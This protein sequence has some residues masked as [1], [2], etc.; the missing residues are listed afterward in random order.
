MVISPFVFALVFTGT[1]AAG[2]WADLQ[3]PLSRHTVPYRHELPDVSR[4]W[5]LSSDPEV[6][7][8]DVAFYGWWGVPAALRK[9]DGVFV[10][11]SR[12]LYA[13]RAEAFEPTLA[14]YGR[15]YNMA[16][17]GSAD[18]FPVAVIRK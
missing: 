4:D 14:S 6:L 16:F 7:E 10:G 9:A 17:P 1:V 18:A 11:N 13:F 8:F 2:Y 3:M 5:Y 15:G 12:G